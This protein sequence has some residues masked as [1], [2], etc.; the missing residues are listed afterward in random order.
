LFFVVITVQP[1]NI[2]CVSCQIKLLGYIVVFS[3]NAIVPNCHNSYFVL[4][5]DHTCKQNQKLF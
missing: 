1:D 5:Y 4:L 3:Y 2:C